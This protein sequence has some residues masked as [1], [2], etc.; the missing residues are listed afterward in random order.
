MRMRTQMQRFLRLAAIAAA[1]AAAAVYALHWPSGWSRVQVGMPQRDV[2]ALVGQPT[3]VERGVNA[4]YWIEQRRMV[5]YE[6][7]V[8]FDSLGR[9]AAFTIERRLGTTEHFYAQQ[10]RGDLGTLVER[11]RR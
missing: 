8:A 6:L 5:R 1:I 3:V 10:L 9:V 4:R 7:W 2:V 11:R